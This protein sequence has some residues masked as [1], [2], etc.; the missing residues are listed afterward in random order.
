MNTVGR[1][2]RGQGT[3]EYA[4]LVAAVATALV[5]MGTYVRRAA[6]ANFKLL[7]EAVTP[8]IAE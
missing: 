7:E 1:R 3:L 8:G 6:Q 4:L 5:A 2:V